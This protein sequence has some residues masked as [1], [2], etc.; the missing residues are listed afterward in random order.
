MI[1]SIHTFLWSRCNKYCSEIA[2]SYPSPSQLLH[3]LRHALAILCFFLLRKV[4]HIYRECCTL[5]HSW[6][7]SL[8]FT[9][10][11]MH[12][13]MIESS[14]HG[15][16]YDGVIF[17][18]LVCCIE[19]SLSGKKVFLAAWLMLFSCISL[20]VESD[21]SSWIREF[22]NWNNWSKEKGRILHKQ[23]P[24]NSW[25]CMYL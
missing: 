19:L 13:Q 20:L 23:K 11:P 5:F 1:Y 24:S 9:D 10:I 18:Q 14:D 16:E 6:I 15:D 22:K 7:V 3:H 4:W 2:K 17:S 25:N 21:R 8:L 12:W